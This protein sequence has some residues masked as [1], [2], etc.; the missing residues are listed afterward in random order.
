[1]RLFLD[2]DDVIVNYVHNVAKHYEIPL[3]EFYKRWPLG[4]YEIYHA[5]GKPDGE[6][7]AEMREVSDEFWSTM[8]EFPWSRKFYDTCCQ[9]GETLILTSPINS[10][11]C[12]SGKLKWLYKF[13]GDPYFN[14]YIMTKMKWTCA[15]WN[16]ILIDDKEANVKQFIKEGGRAVLFPSHGNHLHDRLDDPCGYALAELA[17]VVAE[18]KQLEMAQIIEA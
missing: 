15:R 3:D 6:V 2:M 11:T 4:V 7:W 10:P 1:M 13:T 17:K 8:P 14:N 18:V 9:Y 16:H 12:L 5:I